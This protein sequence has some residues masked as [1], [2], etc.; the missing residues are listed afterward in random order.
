VL[1]LAG[2][3]TSVLDWTNA[4]A[5]D[6]RADFARTVTILRLAPGL[7]D[8]VQRRALRLFELAWRLGYGPP[9]QDMALFYAWAGGAMLHDLASRF[10][11]AELAPAQRWTTLWM[12]RMS[13]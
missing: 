4:H 1:A 13:S 6:P 3:L 9:G 11:L 10:S 5:G 2:R 7:N 8:P 12:N